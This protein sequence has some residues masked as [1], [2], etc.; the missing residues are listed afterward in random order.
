VHRPLAAEGTVVGTS[1]VEELYCTY[2]IAG[3]A[4]LQLLCA[5]DP[6]RLR[7]LDVRFSAPVFPGDTLRTEVFRT[8]PTSAAFRCVAAERGV[9]VL[10][11]GLAEYT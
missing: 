1:A 11:G 2:G 10:G 6:A 3:D 7:R 5:N 9:T 4:I 8:G